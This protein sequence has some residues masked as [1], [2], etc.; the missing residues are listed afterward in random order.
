MSV[1]INGQLWTL[2]LNDNTIADYGHCI[3]DDKTI[4]IGVHYDYLNLLGTLIHEAVHASCVDLSEDAVR[5]VEANVLEVIK[6]SGIF[7]DKIQP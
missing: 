2:I 6:S 1:K 7:K 3:H 5:K 4:K